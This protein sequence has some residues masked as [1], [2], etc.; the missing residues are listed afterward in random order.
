MLFQVSIEEAPEARKPVQGVV[1][2]V[3]SGLPRPLEPVFRVSSQSQP[4]DV[5]LLLRMNFE[6]FSQRGSTAAKRIKRS[7]IVPQAEE[8][9]ELFFMARKRL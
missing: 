6:A 7:A 3:L 4:R 9:G 5:V 8:A 1:G 2:F